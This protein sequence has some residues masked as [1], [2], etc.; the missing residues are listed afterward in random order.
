M[1]KTITCLALLSGAFS[2]A[3]FA[4]E[5]QIFVSTDE[6]KWQAGPSVP[7]DARERVVS[8]DT[9]KAAQEM[10]GFG[11][12]IS[13]LSWSA[14]KDLGEKDRADILD[15]LF[16]PGVGLNLTS[17][18]IPIGANDPSLGPYSCDDAPGDF[19]MEH[20]SVD[21]DKKTLIPLAKEA[22]KRNPAIWAW[23][24]PWSPPAWMKKN[25][26]YGM[27]GFG[28]W[29]KEH[30][31]LDKWPN[32][33]NNPG[34]DNITNNCY[35]TGGG[36]KRHVDSMFIC[37]E[38]YLKAYGLYFRKWVDSY[39]AEGVDIRAVMPQNEPDSPPPYPSC[40]WIYPDLGNFTA[41]YL[42]PALKGTGVEV[43]F[44]SV[45]R[46][47][48]DK[49]EDLFADKAFDEAVMAVGYQWAGKDALPGMRERH[50]GKLLIMS[51]QECRDGTN[52]WADAFYA[53]DSM[54]HYFDNGVGLWTYWN[55]A[56]LKGGGTLWGWK[57]N[58]LVVVDC[59]KKTY[60]WSG[61][62]WLLR[63]VA[64][65][66]KKGAKYIPTDSESI[67]FLNPDGSTVVIA[68]NSEKEARMVEIQANGKSLGSAKLPPES[69][70]TFLFKNTP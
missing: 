20:F 21:R 36:W 32:P 49:I 13:E 54:K 30:G 59:E 25:N 10:E 23:G 40:C 37:E 62:Y 51:E 15:A 65:F 41:N 64:S 33:T 14:L 39:K 38:P 68:R 11:T 34:L 63:H 28:R 16:K 46:P 61:D 26:H 43:W 42:A 50:P 17:L 1:K 67:A 69:L 29:H 70:A 12:C 44:G 27:N 45:E 31:Y 57:Q 2:L 66:V 7:C 48:A 9:T 35:V 22:L 60:E 56:L 55:L 3:A 8:V 6:A 4:V 52:S 18:R 24:C 19:A 58:S 47:W 53:F 5:P